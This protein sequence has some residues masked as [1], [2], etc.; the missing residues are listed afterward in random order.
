MNDVGD[1]SSQAGR[2]LRGIVDTSC[3]SGTPGATSVTRRLN[4]DRPFAASV[5]PDVLCGPLV[6]C[7]LNP[8]AC[9]TTSVTPLLN[10]DARFHDVD[11]TCSEL[12]RPLRD[13]GDTSQHD[14]AWHAYPKPGVARTSIVRRQTLAE[15]AS[16]ARSP[17]VEEFQTAV[18]FY[19][20]WT[21]PMQPNEDIFTFCAGCYVGDHIGPLLFA[22]KLRAQVWRFFT[23]ALLHAGV[24]HLL[25]NMCVQLLIGVGLEV[26][27]KPWRIGPLYMM[28]VLTGALL[29]YTLDPK[30]Y[31]VGASAGVYA[32]LTAHLANVVINWAEMPGRWVRLALITIFLVFDIGTAI[33]R[34]FWS[35]DC[36]TVSHAAHIAGGITGFCFGVVILYN[37]VVS[38]F[39][40]LLGV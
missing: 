8:D 23:Y 39:L 20:Y 9:G 36:D 7:L 31:V 10:S 34:R 4:P 32:L 12:G 22:P 2:A 11:D 14:V 33:I 16:L 40:R 38:C 30:V 13:I 1:M 21:E 3:E 27:H 18:F 26:V 6:T 35:D 15:E 28:A 17:T 25:G 29:Q 19:Y 37:V 24:I 5:N